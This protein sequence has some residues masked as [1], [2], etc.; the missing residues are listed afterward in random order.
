MNNAINDLDSMIH[1]QQAT[2][3]PPVSCLPAMPDAHTG[4]PMTISPAL[5]ALLDSLST[6][7]TD[8]ENILEEQLETLQEAFLQKLEST[9]HK[10]GVTL[11]EKLTITLTENQTLVFQSHEDNEEL[12]AA[13][14]GCEEL[15]TM[16]VSLHKLA[17]MSLGLQY[18]NQAHGPAVLSAHVPQYKM[19]LKGALS[20][21]YL[22]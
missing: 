15:Q 6:C 3:Y 8:A 12:L 9:L 1:V 11:T 2:A 22:K 21:F 5:D 14:G 4:G 16:F 20:H 7:G 13:L 17:L 18:M 19:C 10:G